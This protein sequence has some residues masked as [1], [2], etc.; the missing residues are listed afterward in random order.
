MYSGKTLS[1]C[2]FQVS[3]TQKC[4]SSSLLNNR[5]R[6]FFVAVLEAV[7]LKERIEKVTFPR[8]KILLISII[9]CSM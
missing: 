5:C 7:G 1:F 3:L 8:N 4:P 2:C 6:S 9:L